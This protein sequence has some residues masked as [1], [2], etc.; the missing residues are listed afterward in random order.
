MPLPWVRLDTA[1]PDNPKVIDLCSVGDA[2]LAAAFVWVCSLAYAGKHGT[3]GFIPRAVLSRLNGKA[4][5]AQLLVAHRLWDDLTPKGWQIH[6]WDEYQI[7][8]ATLDELQ[9]RGSRGGAARAAN[10]TQEERS[11]SARKAARARW[12][13]GGNA[14]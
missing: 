9:G 13:G 2:G 7:L 11:E 1:M 14:Y 6:G 3:D 8:T 12:G 5:H 10:M 4:K